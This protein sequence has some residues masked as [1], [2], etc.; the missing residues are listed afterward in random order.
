MIVLIER[1]VLPYEAREVIEKES[2][3]EFDPKVVS[4][5][6]SAFHKHEL[7]VPEVVI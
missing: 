4:A 6:L 2:G 3:R 5:F 7:E 1:A